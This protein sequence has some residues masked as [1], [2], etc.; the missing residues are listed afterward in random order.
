MRPKAKS[1]SFFYSGFHYLGMT[2]YVYA[3]QIFSTFIQY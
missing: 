1:A 3:Q 2:M